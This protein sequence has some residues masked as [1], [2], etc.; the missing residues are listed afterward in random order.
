MKPYYQDKW[1]TI[2][3]GDCRE[4]LPQIDVKVDLV[5]T[6]PPYNNWRNKRVQSKRKNY[7]E[8]TVIKYDN[9]DDM[10][11]DNKYENWQAEIINA[12]LDALKDTGTI[13]YNHK[14]RIFNFEVKS[15]LEWILRTNGKVRQT[16]IWDR[17]G[18]QAYNPV[19]FYRFEEYIYIIGK[20]QQKF[21]WNSNCAK[22]GSIWRILPS[23]NTNEHNATFPEELVERCIM[24]FT[25]SKDIVLDPFMGVGTTCY[26]AKR[27]NRVSIG[28]DISEKYCEIAAKECSQEVMELKL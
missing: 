8:R 20:A 27:M 16:I 1:V 17:M 2:F 28:I 24:A 3:H 25:D 14:D 7:W 21:K 11:P 4:I 18:M 23:K 9:Y 26:V 15:P 19:R 5:V 6:S 12:C 10:M 13:C 22:F